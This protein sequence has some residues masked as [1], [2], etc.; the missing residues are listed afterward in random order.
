[1]SNLIVNVD[2]ERILNIYAEKDKLTIRQWI[3]IKPHDRYDEKDG[4]KIL[5][6]EDLLSDCTYY[7][8][9]TIYDWNL[10]QD[11]EKPCFIYER[12]DK[13]RYKVVAEHTIMF[14]DI[15]EWPFGSEVSIY[16]TTQGILFHDT[17]IVSYY[18]GQIDL[19]GRLKY[20]SNFELEVGA[21]HCLTVCKYDNCSDFLSCKSYITSPA[22][23]VTNLELTSRK[24]G[25]FEEVVSIVDVQCADDVKSGQYIDC[26]IILNR[27]ID[28]ELLIDIDKGYCPTT[29][30]V[31][32]GGQA[33]CRL[34]ALYV[35]PN[36]Q[37]TFAV[38]SKN[39]IKL[40][41][42]IINVI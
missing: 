21:I 12:S 34:H 35:D 4:Q 19:D 16:Q 41:E 20:Q 40:F 32:R 36:Q 31:V 3:P 24:D 23:I 8:H 13:T 2:D 15:A 39:H 18:N 5:S 11:I 17:A 38:T 10:G 33:Q 29:A 25:W 7:K 6:T 9:D 37:I 27:S 26:D 30:V 14:D 42:K 22:N 28:C 1:M